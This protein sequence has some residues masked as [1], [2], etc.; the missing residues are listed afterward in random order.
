MRVLVRDRGIGIAAD[1][2]R[3]IFEPFAR[4]RSSSQRYAGTGLGLWIVRQIARAHG[5]DVS[6]LSAPGEGSTFIVTL[7]WRAG[8]GATA[9]A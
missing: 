9:Q 3:A 8:A 6:L 4:A 2:Q 1:E 7:P 5:G